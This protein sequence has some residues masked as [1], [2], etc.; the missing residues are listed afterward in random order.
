[1]AYYDSFVMNHNLPRSIWWC[2]K[3]SL[4]V[5]WVLIDWLLSILIMEVERDCLV[6]CLLVLQEDNILCCY[7][8]NWLGV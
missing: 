7:C 5:K 2:N 4:A 6:C 8:R 1:M 3:I